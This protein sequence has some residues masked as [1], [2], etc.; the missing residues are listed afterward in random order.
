[1][2]KYVLITGGTSGIGYELARCFARNNYGITIVSSNSERLEEK[3]RMLRN[4]F[5]TEVKTFQQDLS[6]VGAARELYKK[7]KEENIDI[8]VLINNAGFGLVGASERID[9]DKD[10]KLMILNDMSLVE[11]CKL[12]INDMYIKGEGR[13]LN[14]SST[15]AFQPGPYTSTYFASKAFVLS[16]SR[17]LRYEAKKKGV[18]VC[19]LCPGSTKTEFFNKEGMRTPSS[20]QT[21]SFVA[22]YA[23]KKMMKNK[24][25]IVPG[26]YN[27]LVSFVVPVKIK[28][29]VLEKM[30]NVK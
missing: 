3:S 17:A 29:R 1:M 27:K 19:A 8:D 28:M 24:E 21:A 11:L 15:G 14:V 9:F 22:E 7:V 10:E 2:M 16:Y 6:K 4:E 23:Y 5:N 20:A 18:S 25:V 13:I 26:L 12:F 30:K